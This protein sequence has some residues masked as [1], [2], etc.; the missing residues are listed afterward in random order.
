M[1]KAA[2]HTASSFQPEIAAFTLVAPNALV[3]YSSE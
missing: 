2:N 3:V 1:D